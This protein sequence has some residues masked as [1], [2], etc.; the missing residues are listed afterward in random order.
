MFAQMSAPVYSLC[1]TGCGWVDKERV[2]ELTD[3]RKARV[4]ETVIRNPVTLTWAP[5][6]VL[7]RKSQPYI[8]T[9]RLGQSG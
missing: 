3:N 1:K 9:E 6:C 8:S 7:R 4:T 5:L 2:L